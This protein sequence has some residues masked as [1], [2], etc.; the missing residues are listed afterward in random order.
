MRYFPRSAC[1][2]RN[3]YEFV[4]R[5]HSARVAGTSERTSARRRYGNRRRRERGIKKKKNLFIFD[6]ITLHYHLFIFFELVAV[7][8]FHVTLNPIMSFLYYLLWPKEKMSCRILVRIL[9]S[10]GYLFVYTFFL[11]SYCGRSWIELSI[12]EPPRDDKSGFDKYRFEWE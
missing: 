3:F 8:I 7:A 11:S 10:C 6:C 9:F 12:S 1:P 2:S 4:E 5:M